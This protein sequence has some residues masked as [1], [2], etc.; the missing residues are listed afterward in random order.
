MDVVEMLVAVV[1][2]V[3][4]DH[5]VGLALEA[6]ALIAAAAGD[7][8]TAINPDHRNLALLIGTLPDPVLLHVLL[9]GLIPAVLGLFA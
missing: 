2:V 8:V 7:S 9:E 6:H 1:V 3:V 5:L 4:G